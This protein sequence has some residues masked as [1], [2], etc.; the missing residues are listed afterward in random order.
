MCE[1]LCRDGAPRLVGLVGD[2]GSGK[3]TAASAVVR[4]SEALTF[5]SDGIIW[6]PVDRDAKGHLASLMLR[7]A[8]IV[9]EKVGCSVGRPPADDDVGETYVRHQIVKGHGGRGLCCLVVADNVWEEEVIANLRDTGMWILVTTRQEELVT[10][11]DGEIVSIDRLSEADAESVL[12]RAAELPAGIRLPD[13]AIDVVGMCSRVAMDLAFV[14]RWSTVRGRIDRNAWSDVA[15]RIGTELGIVGLDAAKDTT[16][17]SRDKRRRA[18][19]SAGFQYLAIG[20]DDERVQWLY[21]ALGALPDGYPFRTKDA[22]VLLYDRAGSIENEGA[23]GEVVETLERWSI[24]SSVD[25]KFRMHDAHSRFA[26]ENLLDRGDVRRPAVKRWVAFISSPE[27][28]TSV[29]G[30]VLTE[31]WAAVRSVGADDWR[32]TR[33]YDKALDVMDD[34]EPLYRTCM[35]SAACFY[36][37]E[38]DCEG[39]S[40]VWRRLLDVEVKYLGA[41]HPYVM[42]TLMHLAHCAETMGNVAEAEEWRHKEREAF[43]SALARMRAHR[44]DGS[45]REDDACGLKSVASGLGR[46]ADGN[47]SEAEEMLRRALEI[48]EAKFGPDNVQVAHTLYEIGVYFVQAGRQKEAEPLLRRGLGI[49]E[50]KLGTNAVQV[51][52]ILDQLAL[53]SRQGGRLNEAVQ[54]LKR[55]LAIKETKLEP[56]CVEIGYTL[57]KLGICVEQT[58]QRE[59]S[60]MLLRRCLE[61]KMAK[62]GM[63]DLKVA[64]TLHAL[65]VC[66]SGAG[67]KVAAEG[68]FKRALEIEEAKLGPDHLSVATTL[69]H[70][71]V[72]LREVG[73]QS[74]AEVFLKRSLDICIGK[75]GPNSAEGAAIVAQLDL[76]KQAPEETE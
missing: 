60:E 7:L 19:L 18:I 13:A 63:D 58:G 27:T 52:Y 59:E 62:L 40:V 61:I 41:D 36:G 2:S 43:F 34:S 24:L 9:H 76:C 65:G 29:D 37:A 30:F 49:K 4:S 15:D 10:S 14:G 22:T 69:F 42:N 51:A 1:S 67:R 3:T 73:R 44:L 48:E 25:G 70:L 57:H 71:G 38:G 39:S 6:L 17:V 53:C 64:Y 16:E 28:L 56:G 8:R 45:D 50:A 32:E 55:S 23:I 47:S 68:L 35:E 46:H 75:L 11:M 72:C 12:R 66:V 33:P 74:D 31:L 5:F 20:T 26:R 54:L 21:L